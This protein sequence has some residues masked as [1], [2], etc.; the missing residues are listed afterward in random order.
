MKIYLLGDIGGFS[1]E[2][3]IIFEN[4]NKKINKEDVII[5]LGDNFYPYGVKD[6]SDTSWNN[7]KFISNDNQIYPV[8]GNHD[9]LGSVK[10][11]LE[12][13]LSNWNMD[14]YYYKK[15]IESIDFFFIDTAIMQP[16]YSNLSYN[17]VK[18]NIFESKIN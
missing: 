18:S 15:T 10:A 2:T 12:S 6:P 7:I 9:Y 4:I 14:N 13:D 5:L 8:L 17:L 11:Q 16:N 3:K 1:N